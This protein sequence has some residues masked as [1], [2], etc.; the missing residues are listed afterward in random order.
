MAVVAVVA[1]VAV[2]DEL[3]DELAAREPGDE[4]CENCNG[5]DLR[6]QRGDL[7]CCDCGATDPV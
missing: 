1:V 4:V 7:V 5:S 3:E 2:A 6:W